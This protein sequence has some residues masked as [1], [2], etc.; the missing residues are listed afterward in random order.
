MKRKG[1]RIIAAVAALA[2]V[3]AA[4]LLFVGN[5]FVNY[6]LSPAGDGGNREAA[7]EVAPAPGSVEET[8]AQNDASQQALTDAWLAQAASERVQVTSED[9]LTL[10]G[11]LYPQEGHRYAILTHGYRGSW[12]GMLPYAQ[13]YAAA[14]YQT[15]LP[16]MRAHGGSEGDFIGMGWPD[17]RDVLRWIDLIL[18]RDPQ[19]QIVLHG[20]SMGA[21][22]V[23]MASGEQ[24]PQNV[25]AIV[26]DCGYTSVWDIFA[27][28]L[29]VRFSLPTFPALDAAN[30]VSRVRAGY[31]FKEASAL[32]QVA[33]SKT[34]MLF[35]HGDR[36][37]FVPVS[38]VYPL[39]EACNAEKELF[40]VEG[41]GHGGA[42][43]VSGEA[44]W[45][46][47]FSFISRYVE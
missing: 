15:L 19:A 41:A 38:M 6:A 3:L 1:R 34:P 10:V 44:Y 26:E 24:L 46:K 28:E 2:A 14:G 23:M 20:V 9:G 17:R 18:S 12:E 11:T 42:R 43:G 35:I 45:E 27:S 13:R 22:T 36:D 21:A 8:I 4:A 31:D 7:L 30:L 37:D 33:A 47:V 29:K 5:Y 39:Y 25:R 16:S 32:R 40:I